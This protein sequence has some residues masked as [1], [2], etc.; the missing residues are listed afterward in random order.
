MYV[1]DV[2]VWREVFEKFPQ[3]KLFLV[4]FQ[5]FPFQAF[6]FEAILPGILIP[7][8]QTLP[9]NRHSKTIEISKR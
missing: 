7:N 3:K 5:T 9:V 1:V 2:T 4:K 8:S 6:T